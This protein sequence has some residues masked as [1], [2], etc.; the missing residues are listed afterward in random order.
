MPNKIISVD[1]A[2]KLMLKAL[3]DG[4]DKYQRETGCTDKEAQEAGNAILEG[5][6]KAMFYGDMPR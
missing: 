6:S 2:A 4:K 5:F 3:R 1:E